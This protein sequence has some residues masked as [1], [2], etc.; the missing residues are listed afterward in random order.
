MPDKDGEPAYVRRGSWVKVT[1]ESGAVVIGQ[2]GNNLTGWGST[3]ILTLYLTEQ[4]E[5]KVN[6]NFWIVET[7]HGN[8]IPE[9]R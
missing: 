9:T 5:V 3:S 4:L 8:L 2:A 7:L 1:H 6:T